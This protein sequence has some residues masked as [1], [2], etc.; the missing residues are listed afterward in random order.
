MENLTELSEAA[1][2][3]VFESG[4]VHIDL[5]E[6]FEIK[7]HEDH[8][9]APVSPFYASLRPDGVKDGK[10]S[11]SDFL[12]MG[13]AMVA[14]AREAKLIYPRSIVGIPQAGEPLVDAF[15]AN[16]KNDEAF[17]L[18]RQRL[19]KVEKPGQKRYISG[20]KDEVEA[21]SIQN[22][23]AFDDLM[24]N[25]DTKMETDD[26]IRAAG[27]TTLDL[28]LFMNRS[29]AGVERL[30]ARGINVHTV[31]DFDPLMQ[32]WLDEEYLTQVEFD[33]IAA[34]PQQLQD[35]LKQNT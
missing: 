2:R 18:Q 34:Y 26:Q 21:G 5:E 15:Q 7:V 16:L 1:A 14:K 3:A 35:Y 28:M 33:A 6:G 11:P 19:T 27:G 12:I 20:F 25:A 8:P 17:M 9:N 23:L 13:Q 10:L 32:F 4:T 29:A 30:K 31:W 24:S 22:M